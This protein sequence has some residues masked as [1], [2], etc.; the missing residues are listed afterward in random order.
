M[1]RRIR[2][3]SWT[4]WS[5][6]RLL[7]LRLCDLR[8]S[9]ERSWLAPLVRQLQ[10]ELAARDLRLRPHIWISD[11]WFSPDGV[12]GIAIP[13]YLTHPRLMRLERRF[14]LAVEGGTAAECL[15]I[16]RHEAGHALHHGFELQH[17]RRWQRTFGP[18]S[19]RYPEVYRPNPASRRF[20]IH[21]PNWY[22]QAHPAEDFAETF[23]IWLAPHSGWRKRY[24]RWPAALGKLAYVD[25]LMGELAGRRPP[26]RR[27]ARVDPIERNKLSLREYYEHKRQRFSLLATHV[28]DDDLLRI[29]G[30]PG[31]G[32]GVAAATF[33]RRQRAQLRRLVARGTGKHPLAV[34]AVLAQM[35]ARSRE[36]QLRTRGPARRLLFEFAILLAARSVEYLYKR[37]EHAL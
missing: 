13:F 25:E 26:V 19:R 5:D 15:R 12:P 37:Q 16:L 22:A 28:Y 29:F 14:M 1:S 6:D 10:R 8:A 2:R 34:D 4:R 11:E 23:A 32:R 18:S 27:R 33:L 35:I 7:D 20:V 17:R 21:L 24:E 9:W 3:R 31:H 36:L 30:N